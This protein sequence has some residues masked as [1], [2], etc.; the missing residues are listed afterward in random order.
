MRA[1]VVVAIVCLVAPSCAAPI[2]T[3]K[4]IFDKPNVGKLA[5]STFFQYAINVIAGIATAGVWK[6]TGLPTGQQ[7]SGN[8]NGTAGRRNDGSTSTREIFEF[9]DT[10]INEE[11]AA[12]AYT[13][14]LLWR[15]PEPGALNDLN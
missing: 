12:R 14:E 4:I 1:S 11:L 10:R 2:S 5:T 7:S 9:L 15:V 8:G 3:R 6:G 13:R